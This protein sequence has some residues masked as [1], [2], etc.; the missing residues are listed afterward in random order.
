MEGCFTF[1]SG[2][3]GGGG[4]G[5]VFQIGKGGSF[6]SGAGVAPWGGINFYGRVQ[7]NCWLGG[8]APHALP[9]PPSTL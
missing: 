3:G 7:K 2:E 9:C 1:Q 4:R 5:G 6:L 8:N